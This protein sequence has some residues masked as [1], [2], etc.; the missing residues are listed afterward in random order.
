MNQTTSA[1]NGGDLL[2]NEAL[3]GLAI[4][5]FLLLLVM[6]KVKPYRDF[7]QK[8]NKESFVTNTT[9]F[10][11]NN[12]ILTVLRAS[13]LFLV[14]QQ[15]A[16]YGLLGGLENGPV[17]WVLAF[18]FFDLAIYLW[19]VASHKNEFLWRFHKI[20]HSDK[21]F[22]VSTGFRFHVFDLLLEIVY[23]SIFVVV[24]GVNAYLVLSIEIIELFFIF[25][26]H[27]NLRVPNEEAIS[28]VIITPSLHRA[29]HST[30][31]K[32]HDSNYGIVLSIWDRM[33][34]TR[35]ELVP[36][37]IGLDLIEAENFIQLF[38]LAFI[39]ELKVRQLLGWIP[40]G[41]K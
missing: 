37:N 29:H 3:F 15:F 1:N 24:I 18:V 41:K 16:A 25:F 21:S 32:E 23:K 10:L 31:R 8:I 35:K 5:A 17:K 26:H 36:E 40:K 12:L 33:F 20:H 6:E 14:A 11:V 19:H 4:L 34:G 38:S 28:Q 30:L 27:A 7:P 22:N 9:A 39:T 2:F 13:S